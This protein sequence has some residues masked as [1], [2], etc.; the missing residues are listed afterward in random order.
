[1]ALISMSK[2]ESGIMNS[3]DTIAGWVSALTLA[4]IPRPAVEI[5]KRAFLET[6]GTIRLRQ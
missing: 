3:L 5:V 1:M 4:Q 2:G 6:F